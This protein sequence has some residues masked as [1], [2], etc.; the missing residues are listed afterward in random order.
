VKLVHL[1]GFIVKKFVTMHGHMKV[2][3]V[4]ISSTPQRK[5]EITQSFIVIK[6][7]ARIYA[8][9]MCSCD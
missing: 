4:N 3:K 7:V 6:P 9:Y 2:K 5:T 1:I 8:A